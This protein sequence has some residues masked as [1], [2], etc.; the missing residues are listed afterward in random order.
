MALRYLG[1]R[2]RRPERKKAALL[3]WLLHEPELPAQNRLGRNAAMSRMKTDNRKF[4]ELPYFNRNPSYGSTCAAIN[5]SPQSPHLLARSPSLPTSREDPICLFKIWT[6]KEKRR[7]APAN[8]FPRRKR[9]KLLPTYSPDGKKIAFVSDKDGPP[10]IYASKCESLKRLPR[11]K[12]AAH[13]KKMQGEHLSLLVSRRI[14]LAYSARTEGVRQIWI[15][16][17]ETDEE[18]AAH[19]QPRE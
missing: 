10:R 5:C 15:Y 14:K 1:L 12:P 4:I 9:P 11:V 6:A 13:F 17:F 7:D 16:D 2:F 18:Y 19:L 3:K 8:Y